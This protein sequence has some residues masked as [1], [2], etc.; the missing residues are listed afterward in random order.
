MKLD[1]AKFAAKAAASGLT[2]YEIANR[3]GISRATVCR[4]ASGKECTLGN[5]IHIANAIGASV[6][7]LTSDQTDAVTTSAC[8]SLKCKLRDIADKLL[9]VQREAAYSVSTAAYEKITQASLQ[10]VLTVSEME[11]DDEAR[12]ENQ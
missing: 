12:N 11:A 1:K 4:A 9:D 8:N 6:G 5:A 10:L 3:A 2:Q 7:E